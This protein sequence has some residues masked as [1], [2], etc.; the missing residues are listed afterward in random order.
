MKVDVLEL[1]FLQKTFFFSLLVCL[2]I[3]QI[4]STLT[5]SS[6]VSLQLFP[7]FFLFSSSQASLPVPSNKKSHF[8][9]SADTRVRG[10]AAT[11]FSSFSCSFYDGC[12]ELSFSLRS[13]SAAHKQGDIAGAIIFYVRYLKVRFIINNDTQSVS[14]I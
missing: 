12:K 14:C 8:T 1:V 3:P 6:R 10:E 4:H 9:K 11:F 7:S 5:S 13:I 2:G